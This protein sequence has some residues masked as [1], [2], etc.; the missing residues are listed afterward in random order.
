MAPPVGPRPCRASVLSVFASRPR[1]PPIRVWILPHCRS[2]GTDLGYH[3]NAHGDP[4]ASGAGVGA[5]RSQT[6][7]GP[8]SRAARGVHG[9][10]HAA[11]PGTQLQLCYPTLY[12]GGAV[13]ATGGGTSACMGDRVGVSMGGRPR[14]PWCRTLCAAY[15][16]E[17]CTKSDGERTRLSA[18][19]A[20]GTATSGPLYI[21]RNQRLH[22]KGLQHDS[23]SAAPPDWPV[24]P[25]T[26]VHSH[27]KRSCSPTGRGLEECLAHGGPR[28]PTNRAKPRRRPAHAAPAL[29][30]SRPVRSGPYRPRRQRVRL[31]PQGSPGAQRDGAVALDCPGGGVL[32]RPAGP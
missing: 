26:P 12:A 19:L 2:P 25:C 31:E 27:G 10:I 30:L 8:R 29:D 13:S 21:W 16:T 7:A 1:R 6:G 22:E 32:R 4:P 20:T 3:G 23:S 15:T 5:R 9:L 11:K 17:E 28:S 18:V 24:C 14:M